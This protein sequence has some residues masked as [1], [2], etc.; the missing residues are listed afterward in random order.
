M[1]KSKGILTI[2]IVILAILIVVCLCFLI[3]PNFLIH[4]SKN[5]LGKNQNRE[6]E[7]LLG[8]EKTPSYISN[9][10]F[11]IN[12]KDDLNDLFKEL[13]DMYGFT[14]PEKELKLI[15]EEENNEIKYYK[16][17][18][19]YNDI[20]V[21]GNQLVIAT[22]DNKIS[23]ITGHY[24]RDIKLTTSRTL[25]D[26]DIKTV[27]DKK[28]KEYEILSKEKAIYVGEDFECFYTYKVQINNE[29]TSLIIYI[30]VNTREI[31]E[32]I[33]VGYQVKENY[34]YSGTGAAGESIKT[35]LTKDGDAIL[36]ENL[37]YGYKVI[38]GRT[39]TMDFGTPKKKNYA[40]L[41]NYYIKSTSLKTPIILYGDV[42]L[43]QNYKPEDNDRIKS[44]ALSVANNLNKVYSYYETLGR[45]SFDNKGTE[46]RVFVGA[47][48]DNK[49]FGQSTAYN[50]AS[51][52]GG[53]N[54]IVFGTY[55]DK[56]LTPLLDVVAHEFTHGVSGSICDF[57]N[58]GESGALNES[59]SDIMGNLIEGE[60]FD[61]AE[62][63]ETMRSMSD[64]NKYN[65]PAVKGGE[66]YFPD[67]IVTYNKDWQEAMMKRLEES[68]N[69]IESYLEWDNGGVHTNNG[70]PNHAAYIAYSNNAF[71]S[72]TQM[73]RVYY[74]SLFK[75]TSNAT[76]EDSAYAVLEAAK[77]N[78]LSED[79]IQIIRNAFIETKMIESV[80]IKVTGK[81]T[82]ENGNPLSEVE[83]SAHYKDNTSVSIEVYTDSNGNYTFYK[84]PQADYVFVYSKGKY[85]VKEVENSIKEDTTL[86]DVKLTPIE[87]NKSE[88]AE[89]VFVMDIS[90]SMD[91]NDPKDIRKQMICNVIAELDNNYKLSLVTFAKNGAVNIDGIN[92]NVENKNI[93]T[94][95]FNITNDDGY[96]ENAGTNG[97]AGLTKAL[98]LFK[99]KN[100]RKYI[101]FFTDGEDTI[102]ETDA[103][104][105]DDIKNQANEKG[106]RIISIGLGSNLNKD[107]LDSLAS[108]TKG[109]YF[110]ATSSSKLKSY[111]KKLYDEIK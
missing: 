12:S 45:K 21:D 53:D 43:N 23:T 72:K 73:A 46:V 102:K 63:I 110:N 76:F 38:D 35:D 56:E 31:V 85:E 19:V 20:P 77:D 98:S 97:R 5:D 81:V 48:G 104:T 91:N 100:A 22:K 49:L 51:W 7:I 33:D 58:S 79:K 84:L 82:D 25:S 101:V 67:D 15:N 68:G 65:D 66:Y 52:M 61:I 29:F 78:G 69:P 11:T 34:E 1:K 57:K 71:E 41:L 87:T 26:Y 28:F 60:N 106:I 111:T 47:I 44:S 4:K 89:I 37:K 88:K 74:D 13:K 39:M 103:L 27:L 107:V 59:Y 36:F 108:S 16:V 93:I 42:Y 99:D 70:V 96:S 83:V 32:I 95:V 92:N 90:Q 64:P 109:K 105:Y 62:G 6:T 80:P 9:Y 2:I 75:L 86:V 14:D 3:I 94:D 10:D 54:I 8:K 30:D 55:K 50:N 40:N 17:Q 18:Q 24:L